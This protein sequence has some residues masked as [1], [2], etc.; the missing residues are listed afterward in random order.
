MAYYLYLA[1]IVVL[2]V[3]AAIVV[4][5]GIMAYG[6]GALIWKF[7]GTAGGFVTWCPPKCMFLCSILPFIPMEK[8]AQSWERNQFTVLRLFHD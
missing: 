4:I 3:G 1:V 7:T 8:T 2:A 6:E 5:D